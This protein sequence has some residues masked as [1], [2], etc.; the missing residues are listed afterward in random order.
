MGKE[1]LVY[2]MTNKYNTVLY[3]GVTNDLVRRTWEHKEGF[4]STFA[5]RYRVNKLVYYESYE[6]IN[7]AIAREKQIK[8]GSRQK[9]IDLVNSLN[10][11]WKDLYEEMLT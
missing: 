3:T 2:I 9:K 6:N 5:S 11:E 8:G 7:L 10:P 1:Y 4:G